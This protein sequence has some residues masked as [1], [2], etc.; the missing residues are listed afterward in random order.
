MALLWAREWHHRLGDGSCVV[1]G[2]TGS[3]QGSWQHVKGPRPWLGTTVQRFYG[4]LDDGAEAPGRT[5]WWCRGSGRTRQWT[6]SREVNDGV[7]SKEIFGGKF[8]QP[9]GV[10][11]SL[12]ELGFGKAT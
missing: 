5:Q 1:D 9:D 7:S 2:V 6:G 10:S 12:Q 11:E 8:W 4:R 3:G